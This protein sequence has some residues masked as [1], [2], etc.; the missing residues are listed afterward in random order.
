MATRAWSARAG[1]RSPARGLDYAAA[2]SVHVFVYGT[3]LS[4]EPNHDVLG[5]ARFVAEGRTEAVFELR[6][7][8]AYPGLVD[9][10]RQSVVGEVYEVDEETLCS[11][12][13]FEDHPRLYHRRRVVLVDG[14]LVETYV[15]S[16]GRAEGA[17]LIESGSW[18]HR[19][20]ISGGGGFRSV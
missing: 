19:E 11:L 10:G 2:M 6:D 13:R 17:A 12:D 7:L 5:G 15:L 14:T 1:L 20:R 9:G 18:R 3:L 4:G 16:R 8:G